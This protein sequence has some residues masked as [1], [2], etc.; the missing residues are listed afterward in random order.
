[1]SG[2]VVLTARGSAGSLCTIIGE[3]G[4][5]GVV[6]AKLFVLTLVVVVFSFVSACGPT[7]RGAH[8][9]PG[10]TGPYRTSTT[11]ATV[12]R[13]VPLLPATYRLGE[14]ASFSPPLS[15]NDGTAHVDLTINRV[16]DPS[17]LIVPPPI[18]DVT[19]D[20]HPQPAPAG[21]RNVALNV[22]VENVGPYAIPAYEGGDQG[23][24]RVYWELNPMYATSSPYVSEGLPSKNCDGD[25]QEDTT[26]LYA[27][28]SVTG[29]ILFAD[30][31]DTFKIVSAEGNVFMDETVLPAVWNVS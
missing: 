25:I 5:H 29:C 26:N 9:V 7:L 1:M 8:R 14:S 4:E 16:D 31:P 27:G 30:I 12:P 21:E 3:E 2:R 24:L 11:Q 23:V 19:D 18:P 20:I 28:Q 6:R 13:T 17:D 15:G 22:T 10:S